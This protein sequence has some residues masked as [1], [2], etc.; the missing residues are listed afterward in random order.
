MLE[1]VTIRQKV[2]EEPDTARFT[3]AADAKVSCHA[4]GIVILRLRNGQI[5]VA[6]NAGATMWQAIAASKSVGELRSGLEREYGIPRETAQAD[7]QEFVA[8]LLRRRLI[9]RKRAVPAPRNRALPLLAALWELFRYEFEMFLFGF[10]RTQ[11]TLAQAN[12]LSRWCRQPAE[13]EERI[14][15]GLALACSLY[16]KPVRCLQRSVVL[17][18]LLR[19]S[20]ITA[21]VAIGY[22]PDPFFSHAWVEIGGRVVNDSQAY[23]QRM[24]ILHRV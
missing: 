24:C 11:A 3:V 1:S 14:Q 16:W 21:G 6:N 10:G 9:R 23:A 8:E 22:R 4:A 12:P 7:A 13:A 5:F 18:R 20:G 2:R 15:A 19:R 17:A